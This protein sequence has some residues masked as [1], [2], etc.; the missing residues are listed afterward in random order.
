MG[1]FIKI[2]AE[3]MRKPLILT[4]ER[5]KELAKEMEEKLKNAYVRRFNS[6]ELLPTDYPNKKEREWLLDE[7][8]S[9]GFG[10]ELVQVPNKMF[11][12]YKITW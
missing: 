2:T 6:L 10:I 1:Q 9:N 11:A 8:R 12:W 7:L 3:D 5:K 4:D